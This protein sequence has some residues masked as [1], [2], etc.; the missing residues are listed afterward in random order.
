MLTMK[1]TTCRLSTGTSTC[2]QIKRSA[3]DDKRRF[4]RDLTEDAETAEGQQNIKTRRSQQPRHTGQRQEE[5]HGA[6]AG[7]NLDHL[8]PTDQELIAAK[9]DRAKGALESWYQRLK[10]LYHFRHRFGHG[11]FLMNR[12][13]GLIQHRAFET[14]FFLN[15]VLTY[16]AFLT[17]PH[18]AHRPTEPNQN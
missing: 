6:I 16:N 8:R 15:L 18:N 17:K 3:R 5:I 4:I 13:H 1:S 12:A 11:K 9:T 14:L 10:E 7:M 2:R